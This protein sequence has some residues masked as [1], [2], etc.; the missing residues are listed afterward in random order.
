MVQALQGQLEQRDKKIEELTNQLEALKRI[1]QE[2]REKAR[3]VRPP[4]PPAPLPLEG[5]P[6]P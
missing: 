1:D 2:M 4:A 6:K 3:P 5:E